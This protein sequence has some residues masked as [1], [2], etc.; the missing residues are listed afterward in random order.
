M[1]SSPGIGSGLDVSAI[2]AQLVAVERA[3]IDALVQDKQDF[4]NQISSYGLL[5]SALSN[6][7]DSMQN[8]K[9]VNNFEVYKGVSSDDL[10][11]T[12]TTTSSASP[13]SYTI[14][15]TNLAVAHKMGSAAFADTGTTLI[16][17]AGDKMTLTINGKSIVVDYGGKTL[18]QIN[19][20]INSAAGLSTDVDLTSSIVSET[21]TSNR[22]VLTS[23]KT[24]TV[25]DISVSF[26]NSAGTPIAD[27]FTMATIVLSEDATFT[28]DGTY[29]LTRSSNTVDDAITGVTLNL[30]AQKTGL[31]LD[32]NRDLQAVEDNVN[33]FITAYNSIM[34]TLDSLQTGA[35]EGDST[36]RSVENQIRDVL[37]TAP[38]GLSTTLKYL[39]EVGVSLDRDGVMSLDSTK[40]NTA[41]T[42][43]FSGVAELF[44]NDNQG[45][46]FRLENLT[47][48]LL[49]IDGYI[50]AR[51][52]GLQ[53][54]V[55]TLDD[56]IADMEYRLASYEDG[57]RAQYSNLDILIST[58]QQTSSFLAANSLGIY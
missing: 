23:G 31:T 47:K 3:P 50:Q 25:N 35:L 16:G 38:S 48:D 9:S 4:E 45:Y 26:A 36:V 28:I 6:F 24:G 13:G 41:M 1:I 29:S 20:D 33:S 53:D 46:V 22:L 58:M 21:S 40:L 14:D 49:S 27:P 42:A 43:D 56:R 39:A 52:D 10:S 5:T 12:A 15:I 7:Q 44:A 11:L 30:L 37:N 2:I 57:L 19:A 54:R 34:S 51:E 32:V 17:T 8:L 18:S 55:D